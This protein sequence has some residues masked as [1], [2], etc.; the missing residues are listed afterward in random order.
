MLPPCIRLSQE[1][2]LVS[3]VTS[4]NTYLE[5]KNRKYV[6]LT[7]FSAFVNT[8]IQSN[9]AQNALF[10]YLI[11]KITKRVIYFHEEM[12]KFTRYRAA[13]S[14]YSR[15]YIIRRRVNSVYISLSRDSIYGYYASISIFK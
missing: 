3:F 9:Y 7:A 13:T 12:P 5:E 14:I 10:T 8:T 1:V 4:I 15:F 11:F 2:I 6:V